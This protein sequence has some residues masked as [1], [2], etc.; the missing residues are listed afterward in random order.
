MRSGANVVA[1]LLVLATLAGCSVTEAPQ[2]SERMVGAPLAP[3]VDVQA[4]PTRPP[5]EQV[6]PA[7]P[8]A[9]EIPSIGLS[10]PIDTFD[11]VDGNFDPGP[12][13]LRPVWLR[14]Y[15]SGV[16][17]N[18]ATYMGGHSSRLEA[19]MQDTVFNQLYDREAQQSRVV[20]G[21]IVRLTTSAGQRVC[22]VVTVVDRVEKEWLASPAA[23]GHPAWLVYEGTLVILT[24]FQVRENT[25]STTELVIVTGRGYVC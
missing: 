6:I 1:A 24:C 14:G 18:N 13:Q 4:E 12:D 5:V 8:V 11:V 25:P 2:T 3:R 20:V 19:G 23:A 16:G 15:G 9:I 10:S 17:G 22:Y 7:D 21:D